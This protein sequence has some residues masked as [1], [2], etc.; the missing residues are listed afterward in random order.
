MTNDRLIQW[1][2]ETNILTKSNKLN[3]NYKKIVTSSIL[4]TIYDN[5]QYVNATNSIDS[6]RERVYCIATNTVP[7]EC[8][9]CGNTVAFRPAGSAGKKYG[10]FCSRRCSTKNKEVQHRMRA[11]HKAN[12]GFENPFLDTTKIK[13]ARIAKYG[14]HKIS[15]LDHIKEKIQV[16]WKDKYGGHPNTNCVVKQKCKDTNKHKYG[17]AHHMELKL[18]PKALALK[19]NQQLLQD[20]LSHH[21]TYEIADMY[22]T[23]NGTIH[24]W[25]MQLPQYAEGLPRKMTS[26]MERQVCEFLDTLGVEY[27]TSNKSLLAGREIDIYIPAY[28]L[29]IEV[30]GIYWHGE[31]RGRDRKY[32]LN[33]TAELRERNVELLHI[34]DYEIVH[35]WDIVKSRL[36]YKLGKSVCAIGA[37]KTTV[38]SIS[39]AAARQFHDT[40]HIAGYC[41]ASIHKGLF[42]NNQ[43]VSVASFSKSRF[44]NK[45][46]HEIVRFCSKLN[47]SVSGGLSKL[48][49]HS[50]IDN[51]IISYCD[52][53]WGDGKGYLSSGFNYESTTP[54]NYKYFH[55]SAPHVLMSRNVFQKHMLQ[56]KLDTFD[57][58]LTEWKN[59]Q[60]N[61]YDRIWD[62][63]NI[64]LS[65]KKH[66]VDS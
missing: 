56:N 32:H 61:G 3:P 35:K 37:R 55:S 47:V 57:A 33:K 65:Y 58:A 24:R 62:C 39:N 64:K 20:L 15:S 6:I 49:K 11:T 30:N 8:A 29:A 38:Q 63:G 13:Q 1:L 46:T 31:L 44:G 59:M 28:A 22:N 14:T 51:T 25:A 43:L 21:T 10:E 50:G 53:R 17:V 66:I 19:T 2:K 23:S 4:A 7:P 45:G 54:P 26:S 27:S 42:F 5:T 52:L 9:T 34:T 40:N 41:K 60:N 48:V 16:V 12:T 36:T 18:S